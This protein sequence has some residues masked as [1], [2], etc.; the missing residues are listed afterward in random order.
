MLRTERNAQVRSVD[1]AE[2]KITRPTLVY[3]SGFLTNN[4]RN[5]YVLGSLA[6][7]EDLIRPRTEIN[8]QPDMYGWT[9][10]NLK[11]LF[12]LAAY[13]C[14][15][16]SRSSQAGYDISHAIIMPLVAK[17]WKRDDNGNVSGTPLPMDEIRKNL[18]NVTLFGYSAGTVVAQ[19]TFN[20]TR[21]YMKKIGFSE[22]DVREAANQIVLVSVGSIS[23]TA[24]ETN[25]YS[26]LYVVATNDRITRAKN[27]IWGTAGT[28]L[29]KLKSVI[30]LKALMPT[31]NELRVRELSQTSTI[32]TAP[33]RP[34]LY[35]W[36]YD[37][38]GK[39][40]KKRWFDP[41][42]PKWTMARSYHELPH[43]LTIDDN[44]NQLSRIALYSLINAFNREGTPDMS[45]IIRPPQNDTHTP[46]QQAAY[47]TRIN[48]ALRATPSHI[49]R[50]LF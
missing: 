43:F 38:D 17:D 29:R 12:N 48:Q 26:T 46:E 19:E 2:I 36:Q 39:R 31:P 34:S 9:H 50:P 23:R 22:K 24:K 7:V 11:N 14:M 10:T 16:N 20:A 4:D 41:L 15:P 13:N 45:K 21:Q 5:D 40:A 35:E 37:E 44:N 32:A 1:A 30:T 25:R 28:L 49:E 6:R 33:V 42:F 3:L 27:W 47:N 18:K 8:Q